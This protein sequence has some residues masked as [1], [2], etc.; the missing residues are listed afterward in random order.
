MCA[1]LL[2]RVRRVVRTAIH[3]VRG[4]LLRLTR[5]ATTTS[6]VL[7]VAADLVR[8]R[9]ELVAENALLRQQLIILA[10]TRRRPRLSRLVGRCLS[11]SRAGCAPGARRC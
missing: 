9:S 4:H 6:Q 1:R 5:P 10:R 7:G 3:V 2:D 11:C 8:S